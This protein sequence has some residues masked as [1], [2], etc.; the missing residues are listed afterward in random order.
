MKKILRIL[1]LF[2]LAA[3]LESSAQNN[4]FFIHYPNVW[5]L[6]QPL[7]T[8]YLLLGSGSN[9]VIWAKSDSTGTVTTIRMFTKVTF[10]DAKILS[11][12]SV[13]IAGTLSRD[14]IFL[15]KL[16]PAGNILWANGYAFPIFNQLSETHIALSKNHGNIWINGSGMLKKGTPQNYQRGFVIKADSNGSPL[17]TKQINL[18]TNAGYYFS[19][20][21]PMVE[22]DNY[23]CYFTAAAALFEQPGAMVVFR[24]DSLL[25]KKWATPFGYGGPSG[26]LINNGKN[27]IVLWSTPYTSGPITIKAS[28]NL[29]SFDTSGSSGKSLLIQQPY[30]GGTGNSLC[31]T[32]DGGLLLSGNTA[33]NKLANS[34]G[35][36]CKID[37]NWNIKWMKEYGLLSASYDNATI[38]YTRQTNDGGYI[39]A[40]EYLIK[41]DSAGI[42][43]CDDSTLNNANN[44]STGSSGTQNVYI[45]TLSF[46]SFP[47]SLTSSSPSPTAPTIYCY[48]L[49]G[50]NALAYNSEKIIIS[51]NPSNGKFTVM[52]PSYEKN[53]QIEIYNV[54]GEEVYESTLHSGETQLNVAGKPEG[55]YLYRIVD[56]KGQLIGTGKLIIQ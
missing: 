7:N 39:M 48:I 10:G 18:D 52:L 4:K 24:T 25:N 54:L 13:L 43:G 36:A 32:S 3:S 5:N 46:T 30:W 53:A 38:N 47:V 14:S 35:F 19:G 42:S 29:T 23:Y 44:I 41:T 55:I 16:D 45:D 6:V 56:F 26:D 8:G 27:I 1:S 28:S 49:T 12:N 9:S 15:M 34:E 31:R 50:I 40:G 22:G 51:P 37:S 20:M 11:D 33:A 17:L 2:L 21:G